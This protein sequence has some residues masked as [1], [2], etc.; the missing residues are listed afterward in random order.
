MNDEKCHQFKFIEN[1]F[2][3]LF[4]NKIFL[5]FSRICEFQFIKAA[6]IFRKVESFEF[7]AFLNPKATFYCF[8][9][10]QSS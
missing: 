10:S 8:I 4:P 5:V 3:T 1:T 6:E 7:K 9:E 2:D